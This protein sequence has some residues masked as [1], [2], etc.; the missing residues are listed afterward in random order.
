[1]RHLTHF[2]LQFDCF[3]QLIEVEQAFGENVQQMMDIENQK[4]NG[5]NIQ[6]V[7]KNCATVLRVLDI[8][9]STKV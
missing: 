9:W 2:T 1:M 6:L 7:A 8:E 4:K 3:D 5:E